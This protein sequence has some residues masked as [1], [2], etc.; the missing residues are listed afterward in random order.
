M[1]AQ[2]GLNADSILLVSSGFHQSQQKVFK[3]N[4]AD[5]SRSYRQLAMYKRPKV[6]WFE[7]PAQHFVGSINGYWIKGRKYSNCSPLDLG[8]AWAH[9]W[10]NRLAESFMNK[11]GISIFRLWNLTRGMW[12]FHV[13]HN[14]RR[15]GRIDCTHYC[16]PGI[17]LHWAVFLADMLAKM[18]QPK[19][20]G[21]R[22][23]D[24]WAETKKPKMC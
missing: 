4:L 14:G 12:D 11:A 18:I 24:R 8:Q 15:D 9:D 1:F 5:F 3:K 20:E 19:A 7:T 6:I 22:S 17:T 10:R 16:L 21:C 23:T 13:V 2:W